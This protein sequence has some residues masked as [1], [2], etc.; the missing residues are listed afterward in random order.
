RLLK[1]AVRGGLLDLL[2]TTRIRAELEVNA[3]ESCF[4]K[5]VMRMQ[6]LGV[7]NAL[8]TGMNVGPATYHR[9]RVLEHFMKQS[10][11]HGIN[12]KGMEWIVKMAVVFT[13]S[14]PEV[15]FSAMDRMSLN[16][17]E[18]E[19]LTKCFTQWPNV[20]KFCAGSKN[21]KNSEAYLFF[22]DYS[23]VQLLYWLTCL[24]SREAR[25]LVVEHLELWVGYKGNMTGKDLQAM[26]LKGKEI[27]DALAMI[28]LAVID[29]EIRSLEDEIQY[30]KQNILGEDE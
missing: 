17:G 12:F 2:S 14:K 4:R 5:I 24:K 16:P 10:N 29:G 28:K 1:S 3:K 27:G 22:K 15:R 7:W 20:E 8:F 30:V 23:P 11:V 25:R 18:R 21:V 6:E 13:D 26:G 19:Q 9:L